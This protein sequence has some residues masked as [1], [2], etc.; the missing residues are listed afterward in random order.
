M[1]CQIKFHVVDQFLCQNNPLDLVMTGLRWFLSPCLCVSDP[2]LKTFHF[3][4]HNFSYPFRGW[5]V[6]Y[7]YQWGFWPCQNSPFVFR[8]TARI[9]SL[10]QTRAEGP[11]VRAK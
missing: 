11:I 9:L 4:N 5:E 3:E 7:K 1:F 6:N 8:S 2:F 10:K